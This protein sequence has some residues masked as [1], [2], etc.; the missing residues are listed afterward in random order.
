[1]KFAEHS[2]RARLTWKGWEKRLAD[3]TLVIFVA[4][5]VLAV[6]LALRLLLKGLGLSR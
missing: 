2:R 3:W 1:M 5:A 6:A 4:V